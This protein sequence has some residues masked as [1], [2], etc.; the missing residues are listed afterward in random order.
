MDQINGSYF[1]KVTYPAPLASMFLYRKSLIP[2]ANAILQLYLLCLLAV[3]ICT[4]WHSHIFI[5]AVIF[6]YWQPH[7]H[8]DSTNLHTDSHRCILAVIFATAN[9]ICTL[10]VIFAYWQPNL[11]NSSHIFMDGIT[12]R[13][14]AAIFARWQ[15]HLHTGKHIHDIGNNLCMWQS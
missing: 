5:L 9:H 7:L 6:A 13:T 8:I 14:L 11:H 15:S 4:D 12:I 2:N 1:S 3:A 10:A